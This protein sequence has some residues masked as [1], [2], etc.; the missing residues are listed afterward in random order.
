MSMK[1]RLLQQGI[2]VGGT[3]AQAR[4]Y[5]RQGLL[6][7]T[8]SNGPFQK[9]PVCLLDPMTAVEWMDDFFEFTINSGSNEVGWVE[10][11]IQGTNTATIATPADTGRAAGHALCLTTGANSGDGISVQWHHGICCPTAGDKLWFEA[12]ISVGANSADAPL[13]VGLCNIDTSPF[14]S[15]PDGMWFESNGTALTAHTLVTGSGLTELTATI[16]AVAASTWYRLGMFLDGKANTLQVFLDGALV[17]TFTTAASLPFGEVLTPTFAA[18]RGSAAE[19]VYCD[20]MKFIH[21]F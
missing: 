17:H 7:D 8:P 9:A 19:A 13:L 20:Y 5:A 1:G 21:L 18:L 4:A 14:A 6:V 12:R 16:G 15:A 10:T 2:A 3:A 11:D